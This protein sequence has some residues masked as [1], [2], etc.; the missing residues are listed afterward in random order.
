MADVLYGRFRCKRKL[1][2]MAVLAIL[3]NLTNLRPETLGLDLGLASN[4]SV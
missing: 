2:S 3:A 4:I 1:R